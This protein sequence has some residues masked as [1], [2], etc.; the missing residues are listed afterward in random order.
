[1]NNR[2]AQLVEISWIQ[3][4]KSSFIF[5]KK[6]NTIKEF[7]RRS[8]HKLAVYVSYKLEGHFD[9]CD[10]F[11][12]WA[13]RVHQSHTKKRGEQPLQTY[14]KKCTSWFWM[15]T[16]EN[17]KLNKREWFQA[18]LKNY[19]CNSISAKTVLY[20][21]LQSWSCSEKTWDTSISV[22]GKFTPAIVRV[23]PG[24][25]SQLYLIGFHMH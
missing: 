18:L 14:A 20:W 25:I 9:I 12:G 1:M 7:S 10:I 3:L 8:N 4:L 5:E 2:V 22:L 13:A 23:K 11:S 24:L 6:C 21:T 15:K 17:L 16:L 19:T